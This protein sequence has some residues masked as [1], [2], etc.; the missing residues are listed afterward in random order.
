M[1]REHESLQL[2]SGRIDHDPPRPIFA[3]DAIPECIIAVQHNHFDGWV[4]ESVDFAGQEC[5]Q[6]SKATRGEGN[7]CQLVSM[8]IVIYC[9]RVGSDQ[10][11]WQQQLN[12]LYGSQFL[13]QIAFKPFENH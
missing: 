11:R 2:L 1:L 5:T 4:L 7:M 3:T 12:A 10:I 8:P 13:L 9:N 6:C